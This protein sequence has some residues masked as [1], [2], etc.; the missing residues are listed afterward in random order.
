MT[1][2]QIEQAC[3]NVAALSERDI[4]ALASAAT[5][6]SGLPQPVR[7][8]LDAWCVLH[9]SRQTRW[10]PWRSGRVAENAHRTFVREIQRPDALPLDAEDWLQRLQ[11]V[12]PA[13]LDLCIELFSPEVRPHFTPES[14]RG[15]SRTCAVAQQAA[16]LCE[17][18]TVSIAYLARSRQ[19]DIFFGHGGELD[20]SRI[21]K[22][23]NTEEFSQWTLRT[24]ERRQSQLQEV[25]SSVLNNT[26]SRL[27]VT[28]PDPS[29]R[30][31]AKSEFDDF[32][33]EPEPEP[34]PDPVQPMGPPDNA[35]GPIT[36]ARWAGTSCSGRKPRAI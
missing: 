15:C 23:R 9:G 8:V 21:H 1:E 32:E 25:E 24:E 6:A 22:L 17:L 11:W 14:V 34:E 35:S 2:E 31:E 18:L 20:A 3:V 27:P 36:C 16:V 10:K 33:P 19:S 30:A 12:E 5:R 13:D 29:K 7:D 26:L 28:L 4:E